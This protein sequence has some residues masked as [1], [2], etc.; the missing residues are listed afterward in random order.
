M[1]ESARVASGRSSSSSEALPGGR[2]GGEGSVEGEGGGEGGSRGGQTGGNDGIRGAEGPSSIS[3]Q[4]LPPPPVSL[5][6]GKQGRAIVWAAGDG[7]LAAV[8][9]LYED[10]FSLD[11]TSDRGYTCLMCACSGPNYTPALVDYLIKNGAGLDIRTPYGDTALLRATSSGNAKAVKQLIAA[12]ADLNVRN[13]AGETALMKSV[14][15]DHRSCVA[16]LLMAGADD[17]IPDSDGYTAF[18]VATGHNR[19][20]GV[21][22]AWEG[23]KGGGRMSAL[24]VDT[25]LLSALTASAAPMADDHTPLAAFS[26]QVP[27]SMIMMEEIMSFFTGPADVDDGMDPR[28]FA[29][30]S[31]EY[32]S[33]ATGVASA[34]TSLRRGPERK[35]KSID[36][37]LSFVN[38]GLSE[39]WSRERTITMMKV[40]VTDRMLDFGTNHLRKLFCTLQ[41]DEERDLVSL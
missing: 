19:P 30:E 2:V 31:E 22:D 7:N 12:G 27:Q 1:E 41:Y 33:F 20:Y 24:K 16:H 37:F 6:I 5:R 38:A 17:A 36:F 25:V 40:L 8:L 28:F 32:K 39:P 29:R 3:S 18:Q 23:M 26:S 35:N 4:A 15:S 14:L 9:R 10:G 13:N 21:E 11:S 34:F